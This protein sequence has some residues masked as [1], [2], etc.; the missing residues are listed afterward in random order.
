MAKSVKF[1]MRFEI[2]LNLSKIKMRF[3]IWLNPPKI[4]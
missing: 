2:Q 1:K 3:E 4:K